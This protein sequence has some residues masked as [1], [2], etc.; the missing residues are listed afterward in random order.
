MTFGDAPA[1]Y[2]QREM[3][4]TSAVVLAF[5]LASAFAFA[6]LVVIPA[7]AFSLSP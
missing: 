3:L 7:I 2:Y 6:F 1:L 4:Q 5:A